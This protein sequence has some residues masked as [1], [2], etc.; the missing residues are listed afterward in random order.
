MLQIP[1]YV[2][3]SWSGSLVVIKLDFWFLNV[4]ICPIVI[5]FFVNINKFVIERFFLNE[6]HYGI[7]P[8]RGG[9]SAFINW[10]EGVH[11]AARFESVQLGWSFYNKI[12]VFV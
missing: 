12:A 10:N 6:K 2:E 11:S 7:V 5:I 1:S 8:I 4:E 9:H 3:N